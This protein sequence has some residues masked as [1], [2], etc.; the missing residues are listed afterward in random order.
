MLHDVL[1]EYWCCACR[2]LIGARY[3]NKGYAAFAGPLS[4][5]FST[6]RDSEGHGSHTLSTAG[7]SFVPRA[8][9]LGY[10]NGTAKGGSP[11]ARLAAYKVCWPPVAGHQCFD[12]DIMAAFDAAISDGVDVLS[13]SLGGESAE[14]FQD[15]ISIGTFH[16]V[17]RGI[18]VVC[19]AGNSGPTP[20]TVANVSPWMLTVAAST[21]DRDFTTY[22][23]LA[24]N[25][26][27]KGQSLS[28]KSLPPGK[29]FPLISAVGAKLD[30]ALTEE[31]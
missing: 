25:T 20:G 23:Q 19:S 21:M 1:F 29:F 15:G 7:G 3:F 12:A 26:T 24:T 10:G 6:A 2:K 5:S 28:E 27:F 13:V 11:S 18:V 9:V 8:S 30:S 4:E 17:R 16:A 31:A 14:F 22:L